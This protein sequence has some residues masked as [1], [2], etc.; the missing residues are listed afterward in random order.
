[1]NARAIDLLLNDL[2]ATIKERSWRVATVM[3]VRNQLGRAESKV[4]LL[5]AHVDQLLLELAGHG[6]PVDED[7]LS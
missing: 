5:D 3:D 6:F 2:H 1:M 7:V 4:S